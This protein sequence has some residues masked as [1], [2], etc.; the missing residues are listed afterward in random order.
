MNDESHERAKQLLAKHLIEG[1]DSG[2]RV[3]LE[4]HLASCVECSSMAESLD[5][6]VRLFRTVPLVANAELVRQT[7][8]AVRTRAERLN[9]ERTRSMPIWISTAVSAI[10]VVLTTSYVWQAFAWFGRITHMPDLVWQVGFL[11]W[12]FMPA[13]VLAGAAAWLYNTRLDVSNLVT[14]TDWGPR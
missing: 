1:V 14:E 12:W 13:T 11:M 8:L 10:S 5:R 9:T 7:R 4:R 2:E 3:W 6:A